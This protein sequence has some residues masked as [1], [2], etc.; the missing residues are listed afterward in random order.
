MSYRQGW[1]AA[2]GS[3][4]NG[5]RSRLSALEVGLTFYAFPKT[6]WKTIRT[7]NVLDRTF[8]EVKKRSHKLAAA[9][10][11][12]DSCLLM[13]YAVIRSLRLQNLQMPAQEPESAILRKD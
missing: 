4:G 9:F 7:T 11:N 3:Q 1:F 5:S 13:F 8:G 10:R 6:H 12:E 2:T